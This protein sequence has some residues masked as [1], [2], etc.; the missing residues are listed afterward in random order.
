[1]MCGDRWLTTGNP[2]E[3]DEMT[4]KIRATLVAYREVVWSLGNEDHTKKADDAIREYD[5]RATPALTG[6]IRELEE[7]LANYIAQIDR[8]N[9]SAAAPLVVDEKARQKACDALRATPAL[10]QGV[11]EWMAENRQSR[12]GWLYGEYRTDSVI[13]CSVVSKFL[14][15][16]AIVPVE[17]D[18]KHHQTLESMILSHTGAWRNLIL[19]EVRES[20]FRHDQKYWQHELDALDSIVSALRLVMLAAAKEKQS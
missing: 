2:W 6:R 18:L 4:D 17:P 7:A 20:K 13:P 15:G 12:D 14:S 19:T 9:K 5:A 11:E 1:M 16:M 8:D 3:G 10:P